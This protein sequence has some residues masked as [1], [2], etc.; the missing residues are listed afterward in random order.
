MYPVLRLLDNELTR[1]VVPRRRQSQHLS[2]LDCHNVTSIMF[3]KDKPKTECRI[4]DTSKEV[5]F[6]VVKGRMVLRRGF[7][8]GD[9]YMTVA[10]TTSEAPTKNDMVG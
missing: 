4:L 6:R 5:Y 8:S 9:E 1:S 7:F 3:T 2:L 10:V